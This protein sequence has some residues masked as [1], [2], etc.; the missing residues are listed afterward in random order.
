M[1]PELAFDYGYRAGRGLM[2]HF[3]Q[4][5]HHQRIEFLK[6][7]S[8]LV[9]IYFKHR[10]L[11]IF[12]AARWLFLI[13]LVSNYFIVLKLCGIEVKFRRIRAII[14]LFSSNSSR[15]YA[16]ITYVQIF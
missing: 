8:A 5:L 3:Q 12:Q 10:L 16:N 9:F 2:H 1:P 7:L 15:F 13:V 11:L 14:C 4:R 6:Q